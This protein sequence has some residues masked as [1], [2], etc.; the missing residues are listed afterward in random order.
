MFQLLLALEQSS[1]AWRLSECITGG[2]GE[3]MCALYFLSG[4]LSYSW[5]LDV[6]SSQQSFI[7]Y[8]I[9]AA[10][11]NVQSTICIGYVVVR[12]FLYVNP[13]QVIFLLQDVSFLR[14]LCNHVLII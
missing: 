7:D 1:L 6:I 9:R 3:W 10:C 14:G 4:F 2:T 12:S 11:H 8:R 13:P 5:V